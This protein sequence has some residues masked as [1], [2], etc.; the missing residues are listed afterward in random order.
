VRQHEGV[1]LRIMRRSGQRA[2]R[3]T[4]LTWIIERTF[5]WLGAVRRLAKE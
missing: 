4:G 3:V 1:E 2:F 5:A